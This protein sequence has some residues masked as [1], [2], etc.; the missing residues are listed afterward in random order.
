MERFG[1]EYGLRY[2][3]LGNVPG[4]EI[5]NTQCY[6]CGSFVVERSGI[7]Q[8]TNR[9]PD[10]HCLN[11]GARIDGVWSRRESITARTKS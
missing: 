7:A 1:R 6:S 2:V 8:P 10:G 9:M 3:Y 4:E 5:G 11:C